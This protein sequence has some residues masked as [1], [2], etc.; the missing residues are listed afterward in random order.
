MGTHDFVSLFSTCSSNKGIACS[1]VIP[2]VSLKAMIIPFWKD[3]CLHMPGGMVDLVS[4]PGCVD[5][6]LFSPVLMVQIHG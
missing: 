5:Y 6:R 2:F 4:K 1:H 3:D